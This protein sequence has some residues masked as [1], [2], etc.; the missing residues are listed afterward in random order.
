MS[1][2]PQNPKQL[3]GDTKVPLHLFPTTAQVLGAMAFLEGR[4]K[5]GEWNFRAAPVEAMT[6]I[7]AAL[8][9]I[10]WY[11]EG[12]W[13]PEDSLVPHLGLALAC[14]AILIDT[15]YA[16]SLIDNREF[17]GGYAKAI[18]EMEPRVQA[19]RDM[20]AR[21]RPKHWTIQDSATQ[22][23]HSPQPPS[24]PPGVVGQDQLGGLGPEIG[25][26]W[27]YRSLGWQ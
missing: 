14:I 20:H 7:R 27:D 17:P 2:T 11:R 15:H 6:Y 24:S 3:Y 26:Q 25:Q 4:E 5:Y 10:N 21:K 1:E 13:Q 23:V 19:I 12:E 8:S 9:H 18:A 16:G 22:P